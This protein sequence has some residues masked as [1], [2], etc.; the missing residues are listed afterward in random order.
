MSGSLS[1]N[2][3]GRPTAAIL[4]TPRG[5]G[6]GRRSASRPVPA[7]PPGYSPQTSNFNA[8]GSDIQEV[9]PMS[10]DI[11]NNFHQNRPVV[12]NPNV[13]LIGVPQH[14]NAFP[15]MIQIP[16]IALNF[17]ANHGKFQAQQQPQY[18]FTVQTTHSTN[19]LLLSA[20]ERDA[21]RRSPTIMPNIAGFCDWCGRTYDQI[22]LEILGEYFLAT[23]YDAE[24]VRDRNVRSGAF[25]DGFEAALFTFKNAGLSQ[26]R[27]C[28]G[29]VVQ[30]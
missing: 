29:P 27:N 19:F 23:A 25:I 11:G 5:R 6:R 8:V 1:V 18:R 21:Y 26:P 9:Q 20:R 16:P 28:V 30:P 12:V 7:Y 24:T 10:Y 4:P 14:H 22:G 15:L 13:P 3:Y 17:L 2:S